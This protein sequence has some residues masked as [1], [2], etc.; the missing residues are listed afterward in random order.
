MCDISARKRPSDDDQTP[1]HM[2]VVWGLVDIVTALVEM[3]ADVNV[4]VYDIWFVLM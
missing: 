3:N 4:Q 1:L 2:A